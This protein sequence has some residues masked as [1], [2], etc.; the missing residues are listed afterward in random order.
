MYIRRVYGILDREISKYTLVYGVCV[1]F[2][3]TLVMTCEEYTFCVLIS[4]G[5]RGCNFPS[6]SSGHKATN[7]LKKKAS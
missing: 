3:S 2:R 1:R 4:Y 5:L 6:L 7:R